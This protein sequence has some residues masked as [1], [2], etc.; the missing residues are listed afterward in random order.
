MG[1]KPCAL[2]TF[3]SHQRSS[4]SVT[5]NA[6]TFDTHAF[7]KELTAAGFSEPQAEAVTSLVRRAREV[8]LADVATKSDIALL[9]NEMA[10]KADL[11]QSQ[12]DTLKWIIGTIGFQTLVVIG[13][14]AGL[15]KLLH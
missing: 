6:M 13:A 10:T 15:I 14:V 2:K 1:S 8:E 5:V 9:R 11:A 12:A 7:V 4:Y 3:D